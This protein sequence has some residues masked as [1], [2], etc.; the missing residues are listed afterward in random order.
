MVSYE[1]ENWVLE[2]RWFIMLD[3]EMGSPG[4]AIGFKRC[5]EQVLKQMYCRNKVV[6]MGI[7]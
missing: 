2:C 5:R 4:K 1:T 7:I 6:W 3:E